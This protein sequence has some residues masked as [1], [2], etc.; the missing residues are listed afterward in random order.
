MGRGKLWWFEFS[1]SFNFI[2]WWPQCYVRNFNRCHKRLLD[3]WFF[4]F[5]LFECRIGSVGWWWAHNFHF[6][7]FGSPLRS[8]F[9]YHADAAADL[10]VQR[11]HVTNWFRIAG[12]ALCNSLW[13]SCYT[14]FAPLL[15]TLPR[16]H[17]RRPCIRWVKFNFFFL[18]SIPFFSILERHFSTISFVP[19]F[20]FKHYEILKLARAWRGRAISNSLWPHKQFYVSSKNIVDY[21]TI[22]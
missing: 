20:F 21:C 13:P 15:M 22:L 11:N 17:Q 9:F 6:F 16:N 5:F 12:S 18:P 3:I 14:R 2:F 8:V 1:S 4:S 10:R 7:F 19:P